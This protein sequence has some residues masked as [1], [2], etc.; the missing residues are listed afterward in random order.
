MTS[1]HFLDPNPDGTPAVLL[2]HGLGA[3]GAMWSLQC[4]V[5]TS[6]G[7]RPI[8]PD[9]PGFGHS[10]YD[11]RGWSFRRVA[12]EMKGL[13]EELQ[14]GP[15]HVV[16]LS[17]GGVV[18][19]QCTLDFPHLVR[20]LVLVSAFAALRP[21]NV[22]QAFYFLQRLLLLHVLGLPSQARLV[23]K[24]LFPSAEQES[25]RALA[26]A[27]IAHADPRAYRAA[28]RALA[29][30]NLRPRLSEIRAPRWW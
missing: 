24:R 28:L 8:A 10:P 20:K 18:A 13:L 17:L 22:A 30:V 25:L 1:L 5:L 12:I 19:Q 3:S 6:A 9:M 7:L 26:V 27:Q 11:G 14:T 21:E 23:A 4:E 15:V 29:W 16:G 2:L